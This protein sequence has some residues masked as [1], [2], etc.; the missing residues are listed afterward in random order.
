MICLQKYLD[1]DQV[2]AVHTA[3]R[4]SYQNPAEKINCLLSIGLYEIR[5]MG[6]QIHSLNKACQDVQVLVMYAS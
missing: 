5:C 4:H 6:Q 1:L 2:L 3:P